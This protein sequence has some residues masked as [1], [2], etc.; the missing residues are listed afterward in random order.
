MK[1]GGLGH[2]Q[3]GEWSDD[4]QMLTVIGTVASSR[5]NLTSP[6]ALSAIARGFLYWSRGG[7]TDMGYQTS[8]VLGT[9]RKLMAAGTVQTP[10]DAV[11]L[12]SEQL[13]AATGRTAGNG[14]LMRTA[15]V[16][17][18]YLGDPEGCAT[19]ARMV[20]ALTHFDALA[21]DGCAIW[22]ELIRRAIMGEVV[23]PSV[24]AGIVI[25]DE[26]ARDQWITW[27]Q[28]AIV[29]EPRDFKNNGYVVAALQAALSA[30]MP[31][32]EALWKGESIGRKTVRNVL[33]RAVRCGW[34]TDTVA[35]IA[36]MLAGAIAGLEAIP[37]EWRKRANGWCYA[38]SNRRKAGKAQHIYMGADGLALMADR[39]V[40]AS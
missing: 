34:D 4:T 11:S 17:L 40:R 7:A 38:P 10:G 36:G 26:T 24:V 2:Y 31:M 27:L 30:L 22:C 14:S 13:H 32:M 5:P 6:E 33:N 3:P 16:A 18:A 21:G 25:Q 20:S 1:G 8:A 19:A 28:E 9:A 12:A 15:P 35:A 29:G 39:I 23:S 37:P